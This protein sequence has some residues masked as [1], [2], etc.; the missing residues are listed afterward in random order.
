MSH[1]T[2][3]CRAL[4]SVAPVR[5][6][7]ESCPWCAGFGAHPVNKSDPGETRVNPERCRHC[8][9]R[10]VVPRKGMVPAGREQ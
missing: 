10:G 3:G 4:T 8:A 9:G 1:Y 6:D 7:E 2:E 5:E